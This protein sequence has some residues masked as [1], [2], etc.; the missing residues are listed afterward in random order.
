[1][2]I[3]G[4]AAR[5][6]RDESRAYFDSRPLGSRIA[7]SFSRQSQIVAD[8]ASLEREFARLQAELGDGPVPLPDFWGGYRV[9]PDSFEFWQGRPSRL[10]DRLCYQREGESW[11]ISRLSP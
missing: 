5:I 6:S 1:V 4:T 3:L 8:R 7:A 10:H 11:V 9:A 2:R